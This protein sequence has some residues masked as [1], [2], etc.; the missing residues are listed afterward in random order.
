MFA[1]S[2][3]VEGKKEE[4][5]KV[6]IIFVLTIASDSCAYTLVKTIL[7]LSSLILNP[8]HFLQL[9]HHDTEH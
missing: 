2:F 4:L 5:G 1:C 3:T 6:E 7:K 9:Q 8:L